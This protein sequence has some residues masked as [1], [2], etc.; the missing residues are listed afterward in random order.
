MEELFEK[1]VRDV[2]MLYSFSEEE[3]KML[4]NADKAAEEM[5]MH[6]FE[7]Y[8]KHETNMEAPKIAAKYGLLGIPIKKEYGGSEMHP[9]V[10]VLAKERLGQ[11]GMS[12]SSFYNV[13]VLLCGKSIQRWGTEKQKKTHLKDIVNADKIFAFGLTEPEAGSDPGSLSMTYEEKD[14]KFVLNG[15]KYLI[16]NG[17][18]AD[19]IILFAKSKDGG[20]IT[21]FIA[22]AKN[23]GLARTQLK[24]KIGLFSSD[25]GM[26]EF[27]SFEVNKEDILG[28]EGKGMH[29]AYSAL[30]NGRMGV[31]SGCIGIIEGCL[32]ASVKRAR[33]R[34]QHGKAIGKHQLVQE[35][36]AEIRQNLEMARWPVYFAAMK[37]KEYE[38]D[39]SNKELMKDTDFR[40]S[41]AKRIASRRAFDSADRA[42]Q[43][44]G[45]F[46]YSLLSPVGPLF[47]D[48][49]VA[50]IY[51][52]TDEIQELK[53]ASAV[54]GEEFSAFR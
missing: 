34:V 2:G 41:L 49:R 20:K 44:F 5:A 14:G 18:I 36:I 32:S 22:D 13:Q 4:A 53:I 52:G 27:S 9:L 25:T 31:A 17:T 1:S 38:M 43:I 47:C 48:S 10:A 28:E 6:E 51:E 15:T 26:L 12:F 33:E 21:S 54:L 35:H 29:V 45:G 19:Y 11:L 3:K 39:I 30:M 16:S 8:L 42:V 37:E 50:R 23:P 7:S 24:E 40:I 46:G